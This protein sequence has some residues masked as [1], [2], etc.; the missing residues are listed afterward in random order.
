MRG[1]RRPGP[2]GRRGRG[3]A[4]GRPRRAGRAGH[5]PPAA[6]VPAHL[7]AHP[8]PRYRRPG[9]RGAARPRPAA[10]D[11]ALRPAEGR[12]LVRG[13]RHPGRGGHRDRRRPP[14]HPDRAGGLRRPPADQARQ[15]D[16]G[17]ARGRPHRDLHRRPGAGLRQVRL[18]RQGGVRPLPPP[19]AARAHLRG[20]VQQA[21]R[22]HEQRGGVRPPHRDP[23][24]PAPA[25]TC[26]APEN[27]RR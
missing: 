2:H 16:R 9:H 8:L 12:R 26:L 19:R 23:V 13:R 6:P 25:G 24:R 20:P 4:T 5:R 14:R 7:R 27:Y 21:H 17:P 15:A 10:G 3:S 1:R 18:P 22:I 11:T